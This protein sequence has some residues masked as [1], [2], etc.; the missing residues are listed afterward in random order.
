[1]AADV[2]GSVLLSIAQLM[3]HVGIFTCYFPVF[4]GNDTARGPYLKLQ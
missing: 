4:S 3:A 1:M 2:S